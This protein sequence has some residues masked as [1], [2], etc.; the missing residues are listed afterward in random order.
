LSLA[1]TIPFLM[2]AVQT[3]AFLPMGIIKTRRKAQAS[4]PKS[5]KKIK[6]TCSF[7][8]GMGSFIHHLEQYL[9][10]DIEYGIDGLTMTES[11]EH[12][13]LT[14]PAYVSKYFF[15]SPLN[16]LLSKVSYT[17]MISVTLF[18]PRTAFK[19]WKEG[20]GCLIPRNEGLQLLGV[21]FN[22]SIFENRVVD[23]KIIS[24]TCMLRDDS[25]DKIL[26]NQLDIDIKNR[27]VNELDSLFDL[28]ANPLSYHIYRWENGIPLYT[29]ELYQSWFE[30]DQILKKEFPNRN[31]FG[32]YTGKISIRGMTQHIFKATN[33]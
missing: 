7:K 26:I 8:N 31:L 17:S 19:K 24:L 29:T 20:F 4:T 2:E 12:L 10:E 30:M 27:I 21:L 16:E 28:H 13:I 11:K 33:F 1:A 32:N 23:E 15:Q 18:F 14:T 9:K 25:P 22:S 6:G 3:S 5:S